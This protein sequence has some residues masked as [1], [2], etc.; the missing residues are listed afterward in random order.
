MSEEREK[1]S[2]TIFGDAS[3]SL[4]QAI[5]DDGY[6]PDMI[7]AIAR[8]GLL[9]AGA[10]GYALSVK[11]LYTMNVE[12]YTGVDERLDMPMILPPV[13]D[14]IDVQHAKVLIADDVA[15]TGKTL[16]LVKE[17]CVGQGGRGAHRGALREAALDRAV[18]VRVEGHRPVDRVPVER[19]AP[20]GGLA[21]GRVLTRRP[22]SAARRARPWRSCGPRR[23]TRRR[24][25]N[26][27]APV[28]YRPVDRRAV[29]RQLGA[30]AEQRGQRAA[31]EAGGVAARHAELALVAV[32]RHRAEPAHADR[33]S[34]AAR[35]SRTP[36]SQRSGSPDD[37]PAALAA[38]TAC[39]APRG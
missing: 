30:A 29:A 25:G 13:P 8:G 18:R 6:E 14:L 20:G 33:A 34:R 17:F 37:G 36:S 19:Q 28:R 5:A 26:V 1:M 11:N 31:A 4:A 35:A 16:T 27:A 15:D 12:F 10:L 21:A 3:R 32:G 2:W 9:I 7:L 24:P 38:R 23:P 22:A 39:R